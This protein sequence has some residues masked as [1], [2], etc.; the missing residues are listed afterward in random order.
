MKCSIAF[1]ERVDHG[2]EVD[3]LLKLVGYWLRL[4]FSLQVNPNPLDPI[5]LISGIVESVLNDRPFG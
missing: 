3:L 5:Y 1:C 4:P 2:V